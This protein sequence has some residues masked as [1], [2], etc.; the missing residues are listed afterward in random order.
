M[1][2][3]GTYNGNTVYSPGDV[4]VYTDGKSYIKQKES[5]KGITPHDTLFWSR[6]D[7][8]IADALELIMG[9]VQ[10]IPDV[11]N[12]LTTTAAGKALDARQGKALNTSISTLSS[13]ITTLTNYIDMVLP[14]FNQGQVTTVCLKSST[15]SSTK[16]FNITVNDSGEISAT[17]VGG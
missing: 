10:Q 15:A 1:T 3:K 12:N 6:L 16:R 7:Q 5:A 9:A 4:V 17:E 14:F 11:V 2:L 8:A 13:S